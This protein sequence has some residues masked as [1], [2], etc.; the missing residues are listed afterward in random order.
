MRL[1]H[2]SHQQKRHGWRYGGGDKTSSRIRGQGKEEFEEYQKRVAGGARRPPNK[3]KVMSVIDKPDSDF[4]DWGA[5]HKPEGGSKILQDDF[6][7]VRGSVSP[8]QRQSFLNYTGD[9]YKPINSGLRKGDVPEKYRQ[10]VANIDAVM[11]KSKTKRDMMAYRGFTF[12][13]GQS[14]EFDSV[15]ASLKEGGVISDAGFMSTSISSSRAFGNPFSGKTIQMQIRVPKGT[16]GIYLPTRNDDSLADYYRE[17]E[18]LFPRNA[19]FYINKVTER[20]NR[21]VEIVVTAL[22][23]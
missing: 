20:P 3:K 4:E 7:D 10:D 22:P 16:T 9:D 8:A 13:E 11:G 21:P 12:R 6:G 23:G 2:E 17:Y 19:K 18:F 1:K 15:M 5:E 14:D